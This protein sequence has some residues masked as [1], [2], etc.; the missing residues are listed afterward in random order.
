MKPTPELPVKESLFRGSRASVKEELVRVDRFGGSEG[1]GVIH[2]VSLIAAGEALGHDMWIDSVTLEQVAEFANR[3]KT[4]LKSRFTHPS[5]S[6]DGLG[7]H[8]GRLRNARVEGDRVLADLHLTE[9]SH[10]TPDGDLGGYVMDLSEEDPA[11]AGLSIVFEHD[12]EEEMQFMFE[13][14]ARIVDGWFD[15]REF[16]SPD[17]ANVRNLRHVRL[18]KL[19]AAD[20]VDEPAANPE[21]LFDRQSLP[22]VVDELLSYAAGLTTDKPKSEAFGVDADRAT[23]F[24]GRWLDSHGLLLTPKAEEKPMSVEPVVAPEQPVT[25]QPTRE[26]FLAELKRYTDRFGAVNGQKWFEEGKSFAEALESHCDQLNSQ[27]ASLKE[28]VAELEAKLAAVNL[29]E[30]E[31]VPT[32]A[33]HESKKR[34]FAEHVKASRN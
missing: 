20:V 23:Q 19:R 29:G 32:G 18:A 27:I 7:R 22:R 26:D 4:G 8:L 13:H 11:A 5:M 14:G 3:S 2:G 25:P 31:P 24:L 6:A 33:S 10:K 21:G 1:A 28:T 15:A 17:E 12:E 16:Y 30:V 9:S 34:T